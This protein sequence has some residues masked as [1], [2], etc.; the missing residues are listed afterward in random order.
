MPDVELRTPATWKYELEQTKVNK[1]S[2]LFTGTLRWRLGKTESFAYSCS[3]AAKDYRNCSIL[4]SQGPVWSLD[5]HCKHTRDRKSQQDSVNAGFWWTSILSLNPS[6]SS[7]D[8]M[9]GLSC[10]LSSNKKHPSLD[11]STEAE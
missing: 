4:T 7:G 8:Y 11:L 5:N 2:F 10:A 1:R 6:D 3:T 9:V